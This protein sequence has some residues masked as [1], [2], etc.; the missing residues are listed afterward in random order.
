MKALGVGLGRFPFR[1]VEVTR[2]PSGAP[3]LHLTSKAAALAQARG[4]VDWRISLTHSEL[5]AA[6]LVVA[7]GAPQ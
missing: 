4:V 3:G 1:D 7:L 5:M 2:A 6:A